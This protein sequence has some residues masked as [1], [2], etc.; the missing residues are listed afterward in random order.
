MSSEKYS[1]GAAFG[2]EVRKEGEAGQGP[3][4]SVAGNA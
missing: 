2:A 1:R 4:V 3:E